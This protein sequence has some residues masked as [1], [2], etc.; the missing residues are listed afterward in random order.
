MEELLN[1]LRAWQ[2]KALLFAQHFGKRT[3]NIIN[4]LTVL[5]ATLGIGNVVWQIGFDTSAEVS[6]WMVDANKWFII[7]IGLA[8]VYRVVSQ[9]IFYRK[10]TLW[11]TLYMV[12]LWGY[13]LNT[14]A[15]E[16]WR[17][18]LDHRYVVDAVLVVVSLYEI[19]SLSI[20]FLARKSSPT[21]LFA[22]SFLLFIAIGTGLLLMPRC[23]YYD[24]TFLEAL[25][26][27]TSCV[28]VT[29]MSLLDMP[30]EFTPFGMVVI[31]MLIQVGG[32]GVMT[33]TCFFALSLGSGSSLQNRMVIKDLISAD[34]MS[35]IF[36]TLKHI[37]YV[38]FIIEGIAAW[39]LYI[40]F[41][42]KM[43]MMSTADLVFTS[44]FHAIS[45]FCNAGISNLPGGLEHHLLDGCKR[46]HFIV[47]LTII[48]GG[49]GFPLQ[50]AAIN[51]C[52]AR[53][54][55]LAYRILGL[56]R[57]PKQASIRLISAGNRLI[58]YTNIILLAIGGILIFFFEYN[59]SQA[60]E[61]LLN[62][63]CDS[64]FLSATSRTAGFLYHDVM[65]Y[66]APT[67]MLVAVLMWIGCAP[68]STG[69]GIKV[70]TFA[71]GS[72][73]LYNTLV[74]KDYIE[75]FGRRVSSHSVRRAFAVM[76][77]SVLAIFAST[78]ALKLAMPEYETV[79]L[80]F[81][82]C[83][84][85]S[86]A[87]MTMDTTHNLNTAGQIILMIDMFVGRIGVMAFLLMFFS[88]HPAERYKYPSENIMT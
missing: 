77:V 5:I 65:E 18:Y 42:E 56:R 2:Y 38:T 13:I 84:A 54:M 49:A 55:G 63:L 74:G 59:A 28:C 75:I 24:L 79:R 43:P 3:D 29:G 44:V 4:T 1:R 48:F 64:F 45:A 80:F 78:I 34:S 47:A 15:T 10:L 67:L 82:S 23:H 72:L 60:D 7:I 6:R 46:I 8:Q 30:R 31:M 69:G 41:K 9:M 81:E 57:R 21:M 14:G 86:T 87:G 62:R 33:F 85:L 35:D 71:I 11:Q 25:F 61:G 39:L 70:T 53:L 51:W 26:T 83:A 32:L 19:S 50:S 88:P 20:S 40:N 12:V 37:M 36:R 16:G 52:K 66:S 58:F 73:N 17:V 76:M 27:S 68:L 22:G